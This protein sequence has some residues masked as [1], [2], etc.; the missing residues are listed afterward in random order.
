MCIF[1]RMM[2]SLT[3]KP[4]IALRSIDYL[5][6]KNL[7]IDRSPD[8]LD[9]CNRDILNFCE[10]VRRLYLRDQNFEVDSDRE[11]L[12]DICGYYKLILEQRK[13]LPVDIRIRSGW[14]GCEKN[15]FA[16]GKL[17]ASALKATIFK[18]C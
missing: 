3:T 12:D 7:I 2:A 17:K 16:A 8:D 11:R 6:F 4:K 15:A 5:K 14:W 9:R 10:A 1:N 18:I 13:I